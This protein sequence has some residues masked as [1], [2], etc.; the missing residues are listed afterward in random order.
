LANRLAE[1]PPGPV[2]V[3]IPGPPLGKPAV[4][5]TREG[6]RYTPHEVIAFYGTM[7]WRLAHYGFGTRRG[8]MAAPMVWIT[9]VKR[10]PQRK[11]KDYPLPW[12]D[13]R[14]PCLAKPDADNV[15]KA[16]LDGGTRAGVWTD[17]S[18]VHF[19][20]A[21]TVYAAKEE[22]PRTEI[23]I[24]DLAA[25]PRPTLNPSTNRET[26]HAYS[27]AATPETAG[28]GHE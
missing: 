5:R 24:A 11:P 15:S 7:C 25:N 26:E 14:N 8:P 20:C 9:A 23:T 10:R 22:E 2:V 28:A 19:L 3:V 4:A 12:T 16:V 1:P 6:R 27:P 13:G 18:A 21:F 17:D